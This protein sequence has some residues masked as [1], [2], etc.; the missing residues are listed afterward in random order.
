MHSLTSSSPSV[1]PY[2]ERPRGGVDRDARHQRREVLGRERRGVR[3]AAGERD[4]LRPR[5]DRH[6]VAHRRRLHRLRAPREQPRV[7]LEVPRARA[8]GCLVS[9]PSARYRRTLP[10]TSC[11]TS[12][13]APASPRRSASA[14]SCPCCS[15]ARLRPANLGLDFDGTELRVPGAVAVP[16]RRARAGRR[17]PTSSS[18]A[19]PTCDAARSCWLLLGDRARPRRAR[20][21]PARSPTTTTS[22]APGIVVGVACAALGFFAA[23]SLFA[24]VRRRL[25]PDAAGRAP[26]LRRGRGAGRRRRSRSSSRRSRSS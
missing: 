17:S 1:G 12:S 19:G 7:A 4:D 23:R 14:R 15:S 26:A 10:W 21:R 5:G 3:K 11:S 24:R 16:A 25:D 18:A 13:R 8:L 2:C 9:C 20:R 6:E 22:I